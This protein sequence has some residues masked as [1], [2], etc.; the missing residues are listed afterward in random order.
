MKTLRIGVVAAAALLLS[1]GMAWADDELQA[2]YEE[3]IAKPFVKHGG[4]MMDYD[5]AREKAKEEN[6]LIFAYFTRSYAR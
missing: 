2:K 5:A 3:K 4:W 1:A 6:K